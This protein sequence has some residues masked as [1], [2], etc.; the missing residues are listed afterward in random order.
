MIGRRRPEKIEIFIGNAYFGGS[1]MSTFRGVFSKFGNTIL[2]RLQIL[3]ELDEF[4]QNLQRNMLYQ[5]WNQGVYRFARCAFLQSEFARS[6][7]GH[8]GGA[9]FRNVK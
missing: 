5:L 4:Y 1:K 3:I 8:T 9:Y 2:L 7:C 6:A